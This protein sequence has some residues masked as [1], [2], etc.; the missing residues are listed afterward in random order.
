MAESKCTYSRHIRL[1]AVCLCGAVLGGC[2]GR[3]PQVVSPPPQVQRPVRVEVP[4]PQRMVISLVPTVRVPIRVGQR[5]SF[6]IESSVAGRASLYLIDPSGRVTVLGE[7]MVLTG[8]LD[9]PRPG[10]GVTLTASQ[11]VGFNQ[12]ILLVTRQEIAGLSG[13]D[14]LTRPVSLAFSE[15]EFRTEL[16]GVVR[17]LPRGSWAR[18]EIDVRVVG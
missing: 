10:D 11:P 12:L 2:A 8:S 18:E 15:R 4:V 14:T 1:F 5:V 6:R 9:N 16:N 7:N 13:F 3:A 17:N